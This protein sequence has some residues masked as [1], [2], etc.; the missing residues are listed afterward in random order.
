MNQAKPNQLLNKLDSYPENSSR[1]Q[2]KYR[3]L[4][5][6]SAVV[7]GLIVTFGV[8]AGVGYY[9]LQKGP[10]ALD[11]LSDS[12]EDA[13]S[14]FLEENMRVT[15]GEGKI[16]LT[17]DDELAIHFE[18]LRVRDDQ[19]VL[20]LQVPDTYLSID[21]FSLLTGK[22][23]MNELRLTNPVVAVEQENRNLVRFAGVRQ[24]L[25]QAVQNETSKAKGIISEPEIITIS[26]TIFRSTLATL[27][28]DFVSRLPEV[29]LN[30]ATIFYQNR[31]TGVSSEY[32]SINVTFKPGE[33]DSGDWS[34]IVKGKGFDA[35]DW[36]VSLHSGQSNEDGK[37]LLELFF[38]DFRFID[39]VPRL[40]EKN[41]RLRLEPAL[42]GGAQLIGTL[43]GELLG[44]RAA[45]DVGP[46]ILRFDKSDSA[47]LDEAT[48]RLH[49]APEDN[50]LRFTESSFVLGDTRG[51]FIGEVVWPDQLD[52]PVNILFEASDI[53]VSPR[54]NPHTPLRVPLASI[55]GVYSRSDRELSINRLVLDSAAGTLLGRGNVVF[56]ETD[57]EMSLS[58]AISPMPIS[59]F[60]Q[61]WPAFIAG[62]ARRWVLENV[63]G[64][65]ITKGNFKANLSA[66]MLRRNDDGRIIL[67]DEAL[68][69]EL[70][71][72][73]GRF[74][75]VG[76][77]PQI[78]G[79]VGKAV[80]TGRTLTI[81]FSDGRV[82]PEGGG[83]VKLTGGQFTI[84]DHS[85]RPP[86]GTLIIKGSG[87]ASDL[88]RIINQEPLQILKHEGLNPV[89][90]SGTFDGSVALTWL[91]QK[92]PDNDDVHYLADINL[93]NL[94]SVSRI[95]DRQVQAA[96]VRILVEK[97]KINIVGT[98][99]IDGVKAR[100]DIK[101]S[102]KDKTALISN[103]EAT[104]TESDRKK[105]NLGLDEF[106]K[107]TI[108]VKASAAGDKA[109]VQNVQA[110][111]TQAILDFSP[112]GWI[113][114]KG[115]PGVAKFKL[116]P[117]KK[118]GFDISNI[119]IAGQG[120][121][122]R[123]SL[124]IDRNN[125]ISS[126]VFT[127]FRLSRGDT[128]SLTLKRNARGALV[129]NISG[130]YLDL[131]G[132][133]AKTSKGKTTERCRKCSDYDLTARFTRIL[134][135]NDVSLHNARFRIVTKDGKP[136]HLEISGKFPSGETFA[137]SSKVKKINPVVHISTG[138]AGALLK[139]FGAY[140]NMEAGRINIVAN[141]KNAWST[142]SG[143]V[144][145]KRFRIK[146]DKGIQAV[147][148]SS[149][150]IDG[151]DHNF[152]AGQLNTKGIPFQ[153]LFLVYSA[154][155]GIISIGRGSLKGP[156]LGA[157]ISGTLDLV[158]HRLSM[159][160]T[161]I[162]AFFINNFFS[163][164]P[165]LGRALGNRKNEGLLGITYK[166]TGSIDNPNVRINPIS[167]LAPGALRKMFEFK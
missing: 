91:L 147:M 128:F 118:G 29:Q 15:F 40:R 80:I 117:R 157:T 85:L 119:S 156:V 95:R 61:F 25:P 55:Q 31:I 43:D 19:D 105:L 28:P 145:A 134:G 12:I 33:N 139:F 81:D 94:S 154:R 76:E 165:I 127:S 5:R 113:K 7:L 45:L 58:L 56:A 53:I 70:D 90:F 166:V 87:S 99:K 130:K 34:A 8:F 89:D 79:A 35:T 135:Q 149:D 132:L 88:G 92:K 98:A 4:R 6:F 86:T 54:D 47:L 10:I 120:F 133:L 150:T 153:K 66:N 17:D 136:Y 42:Y 9:K 84:A 152:N 3:W 65:Y 167:V 60:K 126:A 123:G 121:D 164:I 1:A 148:K 115:V 107:G 143:Y 11:F 125:Q 124:V 102:P 59:S 46:G 71:W 137:G 74:Q 129:F 2:S 163:R 13:L 75:T 24:R 160:G 16:T 155:D 103:V 151:N 63:K 161:Y 100:V 68:Y 27:T 104:L 36:T 22:V 77:I 108:T 78:Q 57:I 37:R 44:M 69:G 140:R 159:S 109:G 41:V 82:E 101:T 138:D 142:V 73:E 52:E 114:K 23:R 144:N 72:S 106:L 110:D 30:G 50:S 146:G 51:N 62:G 14:S 67:P 131:R 48:V 26:R 122:I 96:S 49:W 18:D 112:I 32:T 64:G 97:N 93:S 21:V 116:V 162:P 111:I 141:F 158:K 39:F 20:W 83:I 38:S